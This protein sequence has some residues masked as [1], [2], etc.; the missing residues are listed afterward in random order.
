[1]TGD[2]RKAYLEALADK[3]AEQLTGTCKSIHELGEEYEDAFNELPF[4][5]RLDELCFEC[6][7]CNWWCSMDEC[8]ETPGGEWACSECM[9]D[10][11]DEEDEHDG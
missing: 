11:N 5:D 4:T 7:R 10:D 3:A 9:Q 6:C 8:E 2:N 1:M